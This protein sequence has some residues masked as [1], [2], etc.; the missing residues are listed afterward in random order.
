MDVELQACAPFSKAAC[1]RTGGFAPS[2]PEEEKCTLNKKR[3]D[4]K[5]CSKYYKCINSKWTHLSCDNHKYF[6]IDEENCVDR[7]KAR[8]AKTC[9]RCEFS[10]NK[11]VNAIDDKCTKFLTCKDGHKVS[12]GSCGNDAYFNEQ[13]Q[14]CLTGTT[15]TAIADYSSKNGACECDWECKQNNDCKDKTGNDLHTCKDNIC[16][17]TQLSLT[18]KVN[19]KIAACNAKNNNEVEDCK[20]NAC[21]EYDDVINKVQC[22]KSVCSTKCETVCNGLDG[23]DQIYCK[24]QQ[25]KNEDC[26]KE[27]CDDANDDEEKNKC[28]IM[29]CKDDD[30]KNKICDEITDLVKKSKCKDAICDSLSNGAAKVECKS[31]NCPKVNDNNADDECQLEACKSHASGSEIV[32]CKLKY[33]KTDRCKEKACDDYDDLDK[34]VIC[35]QTYCKDVTLRETDPETE[36]T[37]EP[38]QTPKPTPEPEQSPKPTLEPEQT[39][40]PTPEP[41]QNPNPTPDPKPEPQSCKKKACDL[42]KQKDEEKM[43]KCKQN[44]CE[45][46]TRSPDTIRQCKLNECEGYTSPSDEKVVKCKLDV[47]KGD[48]DCI[49]T[50]CS[51]KAGIGGC[52]A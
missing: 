25:C 17:N 30:C 15:T 22:K 46:S 3:P 47:C 13:R 11:W 44:L 49:T 45:S 2:K 6:D 52:P 16:L 36:Q 38:V 26:R 48:S 43:I 31:K 33:C 10:N 1:E 23:D 14:V 40:K 39:S 8:P 34:E 4:E 37:P 51:G 27:V 7:Q 42:Y 32:T 29:L 24:L 21:D 9:D 35:K 18:S 5:V 41:E 50:A 28:K 12:E 20:I 19:C